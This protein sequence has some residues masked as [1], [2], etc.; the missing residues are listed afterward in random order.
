MNHFFFNLAK[1]DPLNS[2]TVES[3]ENGERYFNTARA[4]LFN[5]NVVGLVVTR[6]SLS[7]A[8]KAI[9]TAIKNSLGAFIII[10]VVLIFLFFRYARIIDYSTLYRRLKEIDQLKDDFIAMASHELRSPL[11][12]IR[13]YLELMTDAKEGLS[14][15]QRE[16]ARRVDV[17]AKQLND[18]V[19]DMLDVSRME[20]GRME[21]EY[22]DFNIEEVIGDVVTSF[23]HIAEKKGLTLIKEGLKEIIIHSDKMKVHRVFVNLVSN[24]IK[25]TPR[26]EVKVSFEEK[27]I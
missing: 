7:E 21:F 6:Q 8:D 9:E 14:K 24:A 25:Y 12:S 26:G 23:R 18:L 15:E 19:G 2:Y 27:G 4:I 5:D 1:R 16:Y 20:Q 10:V 22:T 17:S 13:G 3:V 11:A